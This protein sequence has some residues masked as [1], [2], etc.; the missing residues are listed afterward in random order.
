MEVRIRRDAEIRKTAGAVSAFLRQSPEPV[1]VR[2]SD[3]AAVTG[4][5]VLCLAQKHLGVPL[6]AVINREVDGQG[7]EFLVVSVY[8]ANGDRA[9]IRP[10]PQKKRMGGRNEKEGTNSG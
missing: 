10:A 9:K 5:R 7:R 8:V 3:Y 4:M 1:T 2:F 6:H